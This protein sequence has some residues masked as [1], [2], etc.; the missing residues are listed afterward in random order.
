MRPATLAAAKNDIDAAT[1]TPIRST[2]LSVTGP[3][4][5]TVGGIRD[6]N[7]NGRM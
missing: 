3:N 4:D 6:R 7:G 1:W 2:F 5:G